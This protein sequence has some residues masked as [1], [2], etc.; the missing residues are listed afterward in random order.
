ARS[1][2]FV[3]PS[4]ETEKVFIKIYASIFKLV[5]SE[6][7]MSDNFFEIGG[8]SLD[9]IWLEREGEKQFDL[10]D[11]PVIQ[12]LKHLVLSSLAHY[13]DS[14][15][16]KDT[17]MRKVFIFLNLARYFQNERPF[18][19]FRARGFDSGHPP[20]TSMDEMVSY[21]VAAAKRIQAT[22]EAMGEEVKFFAPI[23][24]SPNISYRMR[25]LNWMTASLNFLFTR[26]QQLEFVWTLS[27]P[28]RVIELQL[29]LK[30]LDK[31]TNVATSLINCGV[32]YTPTCS[33]STVDVFY[34]TPFAG[35]DVDWL[36]N[37]LKPWTG[38][39][40]GEASYILVPENTTLVDFEYV[41]QFQKTFRSR[42]EARG[43]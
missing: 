20:F 18:Y 6:A 12:I 11:I 5:E 35:S 7:S 1:V 3:V 17:Q 10:P 29:T 23:N 21:Y 42:L 30:K 26:Q 2:S 41:P 19:A 14:T 25:E 40:R 32:D 31:W 22:L 37:Q 43:L 24:I 16:S 36:N 15:H 8:T 34:T 13:V 28:E 4:I 39:S 38:W 33:V 27:P 9:A